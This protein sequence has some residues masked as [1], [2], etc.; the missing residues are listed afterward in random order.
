ML[1]YQSDLTFGILVRG[2]MNVAEQQQHT[3][4]GSEREGEEPRGKK[5]VREERQMRQFLSLAVR[6]A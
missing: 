3:L 5:L 4:A 6:H 1:L 2:R